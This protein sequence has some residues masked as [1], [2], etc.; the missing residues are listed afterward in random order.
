MEPVGHSHGHKPTA[1]EQGPR[2]TTEGRAT[3]RLSVAQGASER[4]A[5]ERS[6]RAVSNVPAATK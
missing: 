1:T 5:S 6:E 4:I 3:E 2:A